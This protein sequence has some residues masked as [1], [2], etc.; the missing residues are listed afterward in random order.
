MSNGPGFLSKPID[1]DEPSRSPSSRAAKDRVGVW[2][3]ANMAAFMPERWLRRDEKGELEF[4]YQ[5]GPNLPFG[6]GV[7]G[8][9]GQSAISPS[10]F[11]K[12][13][14]WYR[15][16]V[17]L[18]RAPHHAH[19]DSLEFSSRED[20]GRAEQLSCCGQD[21]TSASAVLSSADPRRSLRVGELQISGY[22]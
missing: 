1:V 11:D 13:L 8:C 20:A 2:D 15:E 9:F 16:T 17:G 18:P 14:C 12:H 19:V 4:D 22:S 3:E 5:S 7:R 6:L 21:Y 10:C